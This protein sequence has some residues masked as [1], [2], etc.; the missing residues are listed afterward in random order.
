VVKPNT[1]T[2]LLPAANVQGWAEKLFPQ[3]GEV[4]PIAAADEVAPDTPTTVNS[5]YV[6]DTPAWL[7]WTQIR[8]VPAVGAVVLTVAPLTEKLVVSPGSVQPLATRW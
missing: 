3:I 1:D 5:L 4:I 6:E 7:V 2:L 8:Y